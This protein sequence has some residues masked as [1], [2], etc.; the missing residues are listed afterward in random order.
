M[1]KITPSVLLLLQ[2]LSAV[3]VAAEDESS[4][5]MGNL[6]DN[7]VIDFDPS[8]N[9][10]YF[11]TKYSKPSI[12]TYG[13]L[14]LFGNKFEP[15]NTTDFLDIQYFNTYKIVTN[16]HQ[17]PPKQYLLYQ[18][19]TD[20]PQDVVNSGNFD[21]VAPVPHK[22]GLALTQTPQ[23]PYVEM[24]GLREKVIAYIGDPQYVSSPCLGHMMG[25][26]DGRVEVVHDY[27]STI[28]EELMADFRERNPEAIL[29]SGPTNNVE[30]ERVVVASAT[31]ERT[32][33]AVFD[34]I[35]FYAAFYNMEG[36]STRI[37]TQMQDSY[38]CSSDVA[39]SFVQEKRELVKEEDEYKEPT[40]MW[41]NYIGWQDL[42]WS[43][44]ECPTWD[45]TYYCEY[46]TH[47]GATVLSRPEGVGYNKTWGS[48]TVYWYLSDDEMLEMGKDADVFIY[49]GGDWDTVYESK[50]EILDQMKSVQNKQVFDTLGQ[51]PSTWLEQRYAEYD[52]VGLDVCDVVG[53]TSKAVGHTRRWLRN[54]FDEP[55]GTLPVCDVAGGEISKPYVPPQQ[56]C[57]RPE[58][59]TA[60]GSEATEGGSKN[61]DD[62]S[63]SAVSNTLFG[64]VS[65]MIAI[66]YTF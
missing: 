36:E 29:I 54:V 52:V 45:K 2:G 62:S 3:S 4:I 58:P 24:L 13:D 55:V 14:D 66:A 15:H 22:G 51:G 48:P 53:H 12:K 33:V 6:V 49:S 42:G 35:A 40:I 7:C 23:I 41:A 60:S 20:I 30:G 64:L 17:D 50:K 57:V 1:L 8:K 63:A 38:D 32:N 16:L 18:C 11:P 47:C 21:L 28:M 19:G 34:W 56:E 27:N 10:D 59:A 25:E 61:A 31:Q 65:A 44:A 46:A 26:E 37:A 43:V 5:L 9:V 39:R